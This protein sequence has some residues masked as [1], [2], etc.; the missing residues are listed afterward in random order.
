MHR[1]VLQTSSA[2]RYQLAL[3]AAGIGI[4]DH[5]LLTDTVTLSG[6][7]AELFWLEPTP[8]LTGAAL[9]Q[10][11]HQSDR[12]RTREKINASLDGGQRALYDNEYRVLPPPGNDSVRWVRAKGKA[13]FTEEGIPYRFTGTIQDITAEVKGRETQQK[14]LAL[15]DNSIELM[16][17]LENNQTNSYINR[18]GMDM[19]G[20]DTLEQVAETPITELHTPEDIAFVQA[21]VLPAVLE[22]GKWSGMMNVRHLKTGE[23]FPVFNN[24]IR[25]HD[26]VTGEPIA[27]GAVMR[28][29]R[30][31]MAA[32]KALEESERNFRSLVMQAP[33]GIC[34][35]KGQEL[36][37]KL[38]NESFL[39]VSNKKGENIIGK[40]VVDIYPEATAQGFDK[41][42]LSV[43]ES[44][45]PFYGKE[46][47]VV[48]EREE[49]SRTIYVDF[50]FEPLF[51]PDG[52]V[53]RVLD[54]SIDVTDKVLARRKLQ[55]AEEELQRRV[56]ERTAELE[57]KNKELEEFTYVSSHDL[58]EPIRKIKMFRELIKA[59]EYDRFS[60][61]SKKYFNKIGDSIER[62]SRSLKDLLNFA[63]L[64]KEEQ[65]EQ[66]NLNDVL[67]QVQSDLELVITEKNAVI[68]KAPLPTIH[69]VPLQMHQ[70]FYNL[71]NNALKFSRKDT[72][73]II[74][75]STEKMDVIPPAAGEALHSPNGFYVISI[76]DNGIGFMADKAEKIF[77]M[78]QRLHTK[79]EF[80]G[81]GIGL[82][83][84]KKVVLNHGGR[85][86]ANATPGEGATFHI[87]LPV[88]AE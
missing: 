49:G 31:E 82:A 5:D 88:Q 83:L 17:I 48:Q 79:E 37:V 57:K 32:R 56:A 39:D 25:I 55:E 43:M 61:D 74:K 30:P 4:W 77:T 53:N 54:L 22:K 80:D 59:A 12:E 35:L 42:I 11:I 9:L 1:M 62:M 66:V 19:L 44:R 64:S 36:E 21:N 46:V 60:D 34:I 58:Q 40:R 6:N 73:P 33:V 84:C 3:D 81:T 24:T 71:V 18:A 29:M 72:P 16:S 23:V 45:Q 13:Y 28:D 69:G 85:I 68:E 50:T 51:E 47:E 27:V 52:T 86:W 8:G 70:L 14:L 75:V 20:F 7:S 78:F 26:Q 76:S 65:V 2:E 15:V 38:A 63:S 41:M 10:R 87:A 67:E